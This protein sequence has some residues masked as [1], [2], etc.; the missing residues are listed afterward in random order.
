MSDSERLPIRSTAS[1]VITRMSQRSRARAREDLGA[2]LA[3]SREVRERAIEFGLEV[4]SQSLRSVDGGIA[5]DRLGVEEE[6]AAMLLSAVSFAVAIVEASGS[7]SGDF[8][9][10]VIKWLDLGDETRPALVSLGERALAM[11]PR[12][13]KEHEADRL[14]RS[15][16]PA[17]VGANIVIDLRLAHRGEVVVRAQPV[18]IVTLETDENDDMFHFQISTAQ[19]DMLMGTLTRAS[20]ALK[21]A[22]QLASRVVTEGK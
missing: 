21:S 7:N 4:A 5:S 12:I 18:A 1:D 9:D 20:K 13:A 15:G 2:F 6:R 8:A 22:E 16:L 14:R 10:A 19:L 3:A 11:A 17:F